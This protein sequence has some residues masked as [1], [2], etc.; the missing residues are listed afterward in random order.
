MK[1]YLTST[2]H[3]S[4]HKTT[5]QKQ[6]LKSETNR[7]SQLYNFRTRQ[8]PHSESFM[9]SHEANVYMQMLYP[10]EHTTEKKTFSPT[11]VLD[12]EKE[13]ET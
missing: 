4:D 7:T 9:L 6:L 10:K 5:K 12:A 3:K 13:H 8:L 11:S 1:A 2:I